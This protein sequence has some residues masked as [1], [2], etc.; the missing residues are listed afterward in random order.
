MGCSPTC[1]GDALEA[2]GLC[3]SLPSGVFCYEHILFEMPPLACFCRWQGLGLTPRGS[4]LHWI[5]SKRHRMRLISHPVGIGF[6]ERASRLGLKSF[7]GS[8]R[9]MDLC[10]SNRL[11]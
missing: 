3:P 9:F 4:V 7:G 11:P 10:Q 5:T 8:T 6:T 2:L 1:L